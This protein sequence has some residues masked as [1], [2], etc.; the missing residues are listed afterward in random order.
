MN[1]N[2]VSV[3]V[4]V[5]N[6]LPLLRENLPHLRETLPATEI[7][8]I[9]GNSTDG[10]AEFAAKYANRVISD[11]GRGLAYSRQLGI[12]NATCPFVAIVG[13][14]NRVT[15]KLLDAMRKALGKD[16]HLAAVAPLTHI[17]NPQT[18]WDRT[19]KNIF[20]LLINRPGPAEVVG[21]PCMFKRDILLNIPYDPSIRAAG[22]DT[23][24]C[25][26]L[27][28]A[29]YTLAII[30]EYTEEVLHQDFRMY[31]R[32]WQWYGKG[33][34]EFYRKHRKNWTMERRLR[35]LMHP[36]R[37][38]GVVAPLLFLRRGAAAYIPGLYVAVGARYF[39][40]WAR[41]R[42]LKHCD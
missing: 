30:N 34:A 21:T 16:A 13:P 15:P 9:D 26:R 35:S 18:Y 6:V 31:L 10:S 38:Y 19:T 36:F 39:G 42:E 23:D 33:D 24:V 20:Q 32:R 28:Q 11:Q 22:D 8:V 5:K 27:R 14:D 41:A 4:C 37:K 2:S 3:V 1:E 40:W 25:L 29:G 7:I 12:E 17:V